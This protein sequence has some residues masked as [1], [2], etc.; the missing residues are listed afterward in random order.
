MGKARKWYHMWVCSC[1]DGAPLR[2]NELRKFED[3]ARL[4]GNEYYVMAAT[5]VAMAAASLM[6][7]FGNDDVNMHDEDDLD[8]LLSEQVSS[9]FGQ[10]EQCPWWETL[11]NA[12]HTSSLLRESEDSARTGNYELSLADRRKVFE[13]DVEEQ[14]REALA[15]FVKTF[16]R[17]RA[18]QAQLEPPVSLFAWPNLSRQYACLLGAIRIN[19]QL[20]RA[21]ILSLE[22][23]SW[24]F[25]REKNRQEGTKRRHAILF[26]TDQE[27]TGKL[28]E[29]TV[30]PNNCHSDVGSNDSNAGSEESGDDLD[31]CSDDFVEGMGW[32]K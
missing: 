21:P 30:D 32:F 31:E 16:P 5:G 27:I 29:R 4:T 22:N 1:R 8:E 3:F 11:D 20:I 10:F 19:S 28:E 18:A 23:E 14:T 6:P 25:N 13:M 15:L 26:K 9:W 2:G 17:R 12:A 24:V 7:S